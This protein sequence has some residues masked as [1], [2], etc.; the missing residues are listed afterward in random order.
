MWLL[1]P[2]IVLSFIS[3][4]CFIIAALLNWCDYRS[5]RVT[6]ILSHSGDKYNGSVCKVPS[7]RFECFKRSKN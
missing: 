6:G 4:I 3:S 5:M 2:N 7:E 1:I